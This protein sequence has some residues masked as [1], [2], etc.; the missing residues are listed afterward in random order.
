MRTNPPVFTDRYYVDKIQF[1]H[2]EPIYI[3]RDCIT[4]EA[5]HCWTT[6][7]EDDAQGESAKFTIPFFMK[8]DDTNQHSIRGCAFCCA[9]LGSAISLLHKL[10]DEAS[11]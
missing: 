3:V 2:D 10:Q 11:A 9:T 7:I 1:E 6:V 8:I 4:E 5:F